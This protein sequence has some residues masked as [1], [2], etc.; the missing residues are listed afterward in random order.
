MVTDL[1]SVSNLN[2]SHRWAG[3]V[4]RASEPFCAQP[5]PSRRGRPKAGGEHW[6]KSRSSEAQDGISCGATQRGGLRMTK[7]GL[8]SRGSNPA[9]RFRRHPKAEGR[10]QRIIG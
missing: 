3:V 6:S 7:T 4:E 1:F 10:R 5:L 8:P 2:S 9:R